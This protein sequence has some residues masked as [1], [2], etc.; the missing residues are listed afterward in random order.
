MSSLKCF[1]W[2]RAGNNLTFVSFRLLAILEMYFALLFKAAFA[3]VDADDSR[4]Y[5]NGLHLSQTVAILYL[6]GCFNM[7]MVLE[8]CA[9]AA[10]RLGSN[11]DSQ[12]GCALLL[13]GH[14]SLFS[15][16]H[17]SADC[18]HQCQGVQR[19]V[20]QCTAVCITE[21]DTAKRHPLWAEWKWCSAQCG[22]PDQE[23]NATSCESPCLTLHLT[24]KQLWEC[25][26]S[27][28]AKIPSTHKILP[29]Y[30]PLERF[31]L[32]YLHAEAQEWNASSK[33]YKGVCRKTFICRHFMNVK[34]LHNRLYQS[35][36]EYRIKLN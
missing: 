17:P 18:L 20:W 21:P 13:C 12:L 25:L 34:A 7:Q 4:S 31:S 30:F 28:L 26:Y 35:R 14:S 8:V 22:H 15:N 32:T 24:V 33:A 1:R 29:Y 23:E 36:K 2:P 5:F 16:R 27:K 9:T 6:R 11:F 19:P 10:T 3:K